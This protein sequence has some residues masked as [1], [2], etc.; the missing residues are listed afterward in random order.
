MLAPEFIH[1]RVHTAYSLS[2]GAI[3][4]P[5]LIDLCGEYDMPAVGVTDTN[6]MFGALEFSIA[7]ADAGIQPIIGCQIDVRSCQSVD[8]DVDH[9]K[10]RG[11]REKLVLL[12]QNEIGYQN[13]MELVSDAFITTQHGNTHTTL[14]KIVS[15][16]EGLICLSGGAEGPLGRMISLDQMSQAEDICDQLQNEF[17]GHKFNK[18]NFKAITIKIFVIVFSKNL[19]YKTRLKISKK[20]NLALLMQ[21]HSQKIFYFINHG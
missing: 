6:N 10:G 19:I 11:T 21:I 14:E 20:F 4:I 16:S 2:E 3:K 13:L 1:L 17:R 5:Q 8:R 9:D 18:Y 12:V 7:A 15:Y